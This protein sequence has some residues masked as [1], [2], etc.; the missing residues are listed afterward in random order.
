VRAE[1]HI[2]SIALTGAMMVVF[3]A[4]T[5]Y[6]TIKCRQHLPTGRKYGPMILAYIAAFLIML[7]PSRHVIMD[8]TT[9]SG[10]NHY[11]HGYNVWFLAEYRNDGCDSQTPRCFALGG[12][13][14]TFGTTYLGFALLFASTLWLIDAR[15][16]WSEFK[17]RWR[18]I[19]NSRKGESV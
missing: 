14:F 7:E 16:K 5:T 18:E 13:L 12:W 3:T 1:G 6:K 4:Y 9:A 17:Y 2:I 15:E 10:E 11:L 19:R 8:H